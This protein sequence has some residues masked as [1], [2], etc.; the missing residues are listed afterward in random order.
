MLHSVSVNTSSAPV[1]MWQSLLGA[2]LGSCL[3]FC[4][5]GRL[6]HSDLEE[7][8]SLA[9]C[10]KSCAQVLSPVADYLDFVYR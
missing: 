7:A 1:L 9:K 5:N 4:H 3:K 8:L 6:I 2:A 10:Y